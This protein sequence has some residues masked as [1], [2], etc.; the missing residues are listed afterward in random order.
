MAAAQV[1]FAVALISYVLFRRRRRHRLE[2]DCNRKR[3][4]KMWERPIFR[5]TQRKKY[6]ALTGKG[7]QSLRIRVRKRAYIYLPRY[8]PW[9]PC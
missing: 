5:E 9:L 2:N 6:G 4:R 8:L 7:A 1:V 3:K